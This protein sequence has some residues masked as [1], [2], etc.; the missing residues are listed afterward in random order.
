MFTKV[1]I[2][3]RGEIACRVIRTLD[4]MGIGSVAVYSEADANSLHV[5]LAGE[6]VCIGPP[7][8]AESYLRA[9]KI[10]DAARATGAHAIHPGYGFLSENPAF[11]E[12]CAAAGLVFIGPTAGQMRAFGFKHAARALAEANNVPLLPGSKLLENTEHALAEAARVGYPVMLK[13]TAGGGGIGMQL[14]RSAGELPDA[15]ASVDRL[16]RNNFK[17]GGVYLEKYVEQARHIEVQIFGDGLGHVVALGERDCSAQRRNQKVIEE[18][19][20]PGLDE[21]Q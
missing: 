8:P 19:P 9:D 11:A 18:T 13:S 17:Q 21:A 2:A 15:F 6:A 16:A 3:N 12:A 5:A 10:L 1:L 4:R 20:A 14:I 7:A